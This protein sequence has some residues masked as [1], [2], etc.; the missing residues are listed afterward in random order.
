MTRSILLHKRGLHKLLLATFFASAASLAQAEEF[1]PAQ[2]QLLAAA[3]AN[4]HGTDGKLADAIPAIAGRPV[5]VL[6]AQL[7]AFKQ[8]LQPNTTVMDRIAKGY[9]DAEL[10]ALA[11]Y[12][13]NVDK[14]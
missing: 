14:H 10:S 4:C 12:F 6:E 5:M 11:N 1:S 2:V 3:C 7:Q 13:A 8:G 9:T